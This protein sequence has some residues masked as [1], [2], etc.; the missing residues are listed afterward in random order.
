MAA[1]EDLGQLRPRVEQR[2]ATLARERFVDRLW[3]KDPGLWPG[4]P[5]AIGRR[6]GWLEAPER[7]GE[8]WAAVQPLRELVR[9]RQIDHCVLLGMGGSSLFPEVLSEVFG[10]GPGG[11][12]LTVLDTTDPAAIAAVES[13]LDLE[14]TLFV[15]ASKSGTTIETMSLYRYF[16]AK[17]G[18]YLAITDPGT[19]LSQ[20]CEAA[21]FVTCLHAPP[22]V[23]GRYSAL[24]HFGLAPA[25]LLGLD[26]APLL[27][28]ARTLATQCRRP[29]AENPG[30]RLG[31]F[32]GEAA[33][34]GRDKLTL[35]T[36]EAIAPFADWIEQLVAESTGKQGRGIVPIV[37]EALTG[38]EGYG[39]D[40]IF[41][42]IAM[43]GEADR[44][45][46]L[47]EKGQPCLRIE[48]DSK[49][50]LGAEVMRWEIATAVAGA[51]LE[52]NP[53]DEPDVA[54][55]KRLTQ[56][57]LEA[58]KSGPAEAPTAVEVADGLAFFADPDLP[59]S[60]D[61]LQAHL[62]RVTPGD[63]LAI[64]A[65]LPANESTRR[66]LET[67]RN[68]LRAQTGVATTLGYG[69]RFQHSTGQLHKGGPPTGVFLQLTWDASPELPIPGADYDFA[70]LEAAQ[71]LGDFRALVERGRR[72]LRIHLGD[73]Y[74]EGLE[75][76]LKRATDGVSPR[77]PR[78]RG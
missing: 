51:I 69:P 43:H 50:A 66:D 44:L 22:E 25:A 78:E 29:P 71:A 64:L 18:L 53:F 10:P 45:E 34:A 28:A 72:V 61:V 65:Y 46:P 32:L 1:R 8:T 75:R 3:A 56:E 12:P 13:T 24:T 57:I 37:G 31:A 41:V 62:D 49:A 58:R 6:L 21:G 36:S 16:S 26:A 15:V 39:D 48:L 38:M 55:S 20:T 7:A 9:E 76:L 52:V 73:H 42:E 74:G 19:P 2:L 17:G 5:A 27:E 77:A 54:L 14:H 11:V 67:L 60:A 35:V 47:R 63:Y 30:L 33:L 40:R 68:W 70:T 4:D 59:A 23:G